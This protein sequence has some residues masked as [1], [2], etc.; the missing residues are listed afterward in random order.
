M[1]HNIGFSLP[2]Q[3]THV[4]LITLLFTVY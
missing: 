2:K 1:S 4:L 3:Q